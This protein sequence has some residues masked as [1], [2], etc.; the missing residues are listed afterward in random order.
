MTYRQVGHHFHRRK[1]KQDI[2]EYIEMG[3]AAAKTLYKTRL[4]EACAMALAEASNDTE[5]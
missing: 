2:M 4:L 3:A 1:G 5:L